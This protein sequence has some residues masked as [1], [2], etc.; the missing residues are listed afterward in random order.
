MGQDDKQRTEEK[1][2]ERKAKGLSGWHALRCA[3]CMSV[4]PKVRALSVVAC[5]AMTDLMTPVFP[6]RTPP[7]RRQATAMEKVGERP[8]HATLMAAPRTPEVMTG[9]RPEPWRREMK[10]RPEA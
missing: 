5:S 7:T 3:T 10:K 2:E 9:L 6:L 8:R 4:K 1:K